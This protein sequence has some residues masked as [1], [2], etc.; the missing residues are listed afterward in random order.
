MAFRALERVGEERRDG[1]DCCRIDA[2]VSPGGD[3]LGGSGVRR[4]PWLARLPIHDLPLQPLLEPA[5]PQAPV[6][7]EA[8]ALPRV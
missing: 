7:R 5:R 3:L 8:L 4:A 2:R 6:R 1:F